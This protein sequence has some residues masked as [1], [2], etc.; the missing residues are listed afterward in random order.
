MVKPVPRTGLDGY[1]EQFENG[2]YRHW[3]VS[4]DVRAKKKSYSESM[5]AYEKSQEEV[6]NAKGASEKLAA[7]KEMLAGFES[8]EQ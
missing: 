2:T 7:V 8:L 5:K 3:M 4:Q 1:L 6:Q